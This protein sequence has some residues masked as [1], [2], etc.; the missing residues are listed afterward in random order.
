[1]LIPKPLNRIKFK[2]QKKSENNKSRFNRIENGK[3]PNTCKFF[4]IS[5]KVWNFK[6]KE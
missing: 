6:Q 4:K 1:M 3:I 2:K 5:F